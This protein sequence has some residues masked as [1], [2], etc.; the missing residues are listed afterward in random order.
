[1][2]GA[3]GATTKFI[4]SGNRARVLQRA[5]DHWRSVNSTP[6]PEV[7]LIDAFPE[8]QE[9]PVCVSADIQHP[10][11]LPYGERVVIAA[12]ASVLNPKVVFEFGTFKGA[13][14]ALI[15]D[16]CPPD[17]TIHTLDLPPSFLAGT[18]VSDDDIGMRF[19]GNARYTGR[20]VQHRSDSRQFDYSAL[21][22]KVDLVYVDGSHKFDDV[23]ADSRMAL[24]MLSPSG[25][26]VWDDYQLSALPVMAALDE[27]A[28]EVYL[29]RVFGT[30]LAVYRSGRQRT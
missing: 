11:E 3:L 29:E 20:I 22:G 7:F 19:R 21:T 28:R 27:L 1:M 9:R 4:G 25:V 5:I 23:L 12:I 26:I 16:V 17:V 13:T 15:A 8:I 2:L 24:K 10:F 30:R 18:S 6:L 14:T